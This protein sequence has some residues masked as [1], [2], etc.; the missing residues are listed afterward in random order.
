MLTFSKSC[1]YNGV[2]VISV[3]TADQ[4]AATPDLLHLTQRKTLK[5]WYVQTPDHYV[6]TQWVRGRT[7][8]Y[9]LEGLTLQEAKA[10]A[11]LCLAHECRMEQAYRDPA[12]AALRKKVHARQR[13]RP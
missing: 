4:D 5:G 10:F 11:A 6:G 8:V 13:R 3:R 2:K 7:L 1:T 9:S 12:F